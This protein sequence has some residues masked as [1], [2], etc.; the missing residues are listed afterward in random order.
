VDRGT[1][2]RRNNE[3]AFKATGIFSLDHD[4]IPH[5]F[6]LIYDAAE[7]VEETEADRSQSPVNNSF[8]HTSSAS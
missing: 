1:E 5:S 2:L 6:F 3:S 7:T 4:T 8:W